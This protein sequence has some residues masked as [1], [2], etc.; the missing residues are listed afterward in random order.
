MLRCAKMPMVRAPLAFG[1]FTS[2]HGMKYSALQPR[3]VRAVAPRQAPSQLSLY[4]R[5]GRMVPSEMLL[6]RLSWNQNP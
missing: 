5:S 6:P 3:S 2:D 1:M 4:W